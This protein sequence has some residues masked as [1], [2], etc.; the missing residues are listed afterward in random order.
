MLSHKMNKVQKKTQVTLWDDAPAQ[1]LF[2]SGT[3]WRWQTFQDS[4]CLCLS[5][6]RPA[7]RRMAETPVARHAN[8]RPTR[9]SYFLKGETAAVSL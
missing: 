1:Q 5:C 7:E 2:P 9:R 3:I 6:H 8:R 4:G